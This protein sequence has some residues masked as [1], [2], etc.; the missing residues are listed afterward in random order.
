MRQTDYY[1]ELLRQLRSLFPSTDAMRQAFVQR[2]HDHLFRDLAV[3]ANRY[4]Y[5]LAEYKQVW[6]GFELATES[7]VLVNY[8][9]Y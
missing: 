5:N 9:W 7:R 2:S 1:L 6:L 3:E 4:A 8:A